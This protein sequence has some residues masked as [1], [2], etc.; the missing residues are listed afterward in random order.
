MGKKRAYILTSFGEPRNEE[1]VASYIQSHFAYN[2]P[3]RR[4]KNWLDRLFFSGKIHREI[5]RYKKELTSLP[6]FPPSFAQLLSWKEE[7]SQYLQSPFFCF[8][9]HL[10]W[11]HPSFFEEIKNY[12]AEEYYL[13]PTFP[14]FSYALTG[15]I[16]YFFSKKLKNEFL[17]RFRW[18][19][20]YP[21][22]PVFVQA[23]Q[24]KIQNFMSENHLKE[25]ELILLFSCAG[26]DKNYLENGDLYESE[27]ELSFKEILKAFPFALGKLSFQ[28]E[29]AKRSSPLQPSTFALCEEIDSWCER[30]RSVLLIPLSFLVDSLS[31]LFEM[32]LLYLPILQRKGFAAFRL[33]VISSELEWAKNSLDLFKEKNFVSNQMLL[34]FPNEEKVSS[35]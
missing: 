7:A 19:K 8:F 4:K 34:Y 18:L 6:S 27:C 31:T 14:Q 24:Q 16:A 20:S 9:L 32:D 26:I 21:A 17:H 22:H 13:L 2:D 33:P 23:Y 30:R 11:T 3:F 5:S 15:Q 28:A 10:P 1:E 29:Y 12:N 25:E 35:L